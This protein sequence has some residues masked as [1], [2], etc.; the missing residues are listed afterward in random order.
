MEK[1][2][3]IGNQQPLIYYFNKH[4]KNKTI[5]IKQKESIKNTNNKLFVFLRTLEK[6]VS[7]HHYPLS[8]LAT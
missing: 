5:K 6:A 8:H 7:P 1:Y 4:N 2:S 3:M